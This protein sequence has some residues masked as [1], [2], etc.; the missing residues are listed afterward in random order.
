[1]YCKGWSSW[2]VYVWLSSEVTPIENQEWFLVNKP[3]STVYVQCVI[4]VMN[5]NRPQTAMNAGWITFKR[6]TILIVR[7]ESYVLLVWLGCHPSHICDE[8]TSSELHSAR[9]VL[10]TLEA[11]E[12]WTRRVSTLFRSLWIVVVD[13]T[14]IRPLVRVIGMP[15]DSRDGNLLYDVRRFLKR[16]V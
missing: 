7:D 10:Y 9:Q 13:L 1:M 4:E 12:A 6:E 2:S 3:W 5:C 11:Q 8:R 15:I 14:R 16:T